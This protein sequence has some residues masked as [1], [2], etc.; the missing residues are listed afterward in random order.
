MSPSPP[1]SKRLKSHG[2]PSPPQSTTS[3]AAAPGGDGGT[4]DNI[5]LSDEQFAEKLA[6]QFEQKEIGIGEFLGQLMQHQDSKLAAKLAGQKKEL[7]EDG[8]AKLAAKLAEQKKELQE[9][10]SL[11]NGRINQIAECLKPATDF[12]GLETAVYLFVEK[13]LPASWDQGFSKDKIQ[14][15]VAV[16]C[17][18]VLKVLVDDKKSCPKSFS[19]Q[20][21]ST[22]KNNKALGH[23]K[24][25]DKELFRV[26][27]AGMYG[28]LGFVSINEQTMIMN[29]ADTKNRN[30]LVHDGALIDSIFGTPRKEHKDG[31]NYTAS[32]ETARSNKQNLQN[33]ANLYTEPSMSTKTFQTVVEDLAKMLER[34]GFHPDNED[35]KKVVQNLNGMTK[36]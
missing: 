14:Y 35:V 21:P 13:V 31:S 2:G 17:S 12:A 3:A 28:L 19:W 36:I 29:V 8:S 7:Q 32:K 1:A 24:F 5:I 6:R 16:V 34:K 10:T 11:L 26:T 9:E 4:E 20:G 22:T 25:P 23:G 15:G 18:D 30:P 27:L 33:A